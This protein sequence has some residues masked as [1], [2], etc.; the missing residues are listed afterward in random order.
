[1]LIRGGRVEG[2]CR[3]CAITWARNAGFCRRGQPVAEPFEV[4]AKRAKGGAAKK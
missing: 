1:V 2:S 3:A 4:C